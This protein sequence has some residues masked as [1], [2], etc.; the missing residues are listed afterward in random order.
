MSGEFVTLTDAK[1]ITG[2]AASG[3]NAFIVDLANLQT[4]IAG[5]GAD[6][7]LI[8]PGVNT[9]GSATI[10]IT[11]Y[12]SGVP[13]YYTNGDGNQYVLEHVLPYTAG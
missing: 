5:I 1:I 8:E 10:V 11:C 2:K 6:Q 3:S 12:K 7:I 4:Y 9:D 13:Q